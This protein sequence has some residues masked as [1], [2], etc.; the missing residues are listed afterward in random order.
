[1]KFKVGDILVHINGI[2]TTKVITKVITEVGIDYYRID[3]LDREKE[4]VSSGFSKDYIERI[5]RKL[6]PLEKALK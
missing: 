4:G 3:Y 1:M 2:Y 5:Y 6:T